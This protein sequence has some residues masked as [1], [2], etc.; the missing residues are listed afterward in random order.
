M[1]S[2]HFH[3]A[4]ILMA[5]LVILGVIYCVKQSSDYDPYGIGAT[6]GCLVLVFAILLA[7]IL[8]GIFIW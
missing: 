7:L 3:W 5:V 4:W 8:G 1:I 6:V 2:L